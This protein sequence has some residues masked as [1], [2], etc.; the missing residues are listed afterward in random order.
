M[1]LKAFHVVFVTV[2]T[3]LAFGFGFWGITEYQAS[4]EP[5]YLAMGGGSLVA[6]GALVVYGRYFLKKLKK[7]SYL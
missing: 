1:S 3:L 5:A 7:I 6:G 2:S 4:R